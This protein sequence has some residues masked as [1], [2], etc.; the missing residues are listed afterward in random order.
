MRRVGIFV[1]W[2]AL[3]CVAV[4]GEA[5]AESRSAAS[6]ARS[7]AG[8]AP[9]SSSMAL[10]IGID[11]YDNGWRPLNKA[12]E[13]A[14]AVKTALEN[15]GF[16]RVEIV[17]NPTRN[18]LEDAF[19]NFVYTMG[20]DP[21]ARL[22]IWFA[23]H[24]HTIRGEG[25]L[26]PRDAPL[27]GASP[28]ADARFRAAA[29]SMRRFGEYLRE[30][31]ARHVLAVFDS[32]FAGTIFNATRSFQAPPVIQA[33]SSRQ[34]RQIITS[35]SAGEEVADDGLFR[36][37]FVEALG[38]DAGGR[39]SSGYLTG[40]RLGSYLEERMVNYTDRRQHPVYGKLAHPDYDAGDFVFPDVVPGSGGA[41]EIA[42]LDETAP[43][44][45]SVEVRGATPELRILAP[46]A[47]RANKDVAYVADKLSRNLVELFSDSG[48]KVSSELTS[49]EP[50]RNPTHE[51]HLSL[52][53]EG[54]DLTIEADFTGPDGISLATASL[55]GPVDFFRRHYKILPA[56]ILYAADISAANLDPLLTV[57]PPTA[58]SL[59]YAMF[60]AA[61]RAASERRFELATDLLENALEVDDR[62][63]AAHEALA[64]LLDLAGDADAAARQRAEALA[65]DPDFT[66]LAIFGET[67]MG[68]PVPA[69]LAA[70]QKAGWSELEAGLEYWSAEAPDYGV[71]LNAW[72]FDPERFQLG[73]AVA[74]NMN[75]ENAGTFRSSR[76][77]VLAINAGFF[78]LDIRSRLTPVG[79]AVSDKRELSPF[80]PEKAKNPLTGVLIRSGDKV[81]VQPAARFQPGTSYDMAL[82]AGPLVVDPGGINGIVRNSFD[83]L[84]RS[85]F[86]ID[87][88]GNPVIV[89]LSG[90]LSLFEFGDFLS[91]APM[92]GGLG[93]ERA[94]NL[95]GG[96]SSQVSVASEGGVFEAP[97]LWKVH[98]ALILQRR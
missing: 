14:E 62:F 85:A 63:A 37:L 9:F 97:G 46:D 90:G 17:R 38:A 83:R 54:E 92:D 39:D 50:L 10:V 28:E 64:E 55:S 41:G 70:G 35:G 68:N 56:A 52:G 57:K 18:E 23:G 5:F 21:D 84:D 12:V 81:E 2:A 42:S 44:S 11:Q 6:L 30:I 29:L 59:A 96:P 72:R 36:R 89:R 78:D 43:P 66:R 33:A 71:A 22:L 58:S 93:C 53:A 51:L 75:G 45:T 86:C 98:N 61:R 76:E 80:D 31:N 25:Y 20:S 82:Q 26:V 1:C 7:A 3:L 73:L 88:N 95:D 13:D 4:A 27:P 24:G 67:L 87:F 16:D 94:I 40:S 32:C 48:M 15:S 77:A 19:R 34:V 91:R 65:I 74:D 60:L 8:A 79:L 49:R 47:D 69:L